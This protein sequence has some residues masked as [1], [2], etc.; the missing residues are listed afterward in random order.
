MSIMAPIPH[1]K[2]RLIQ[3]AIHKTRDK[4]YARRLAVMLM[5]HRGDTVSHTA[6]TLCATRSS[7]G[8]WIIFGSEGLQSL[9]PG[10]YNT[11]DGYVHAGKKL[12]YRLK[13]KAF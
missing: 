7:V 6:R 1:P 12:F 3:K 9:L 2:Q 13:L 4:D 8:R 5:L 11:L 10:R